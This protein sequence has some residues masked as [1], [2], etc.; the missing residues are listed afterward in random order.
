MK[1]RDSLSRPVVPPATTPRPAVTPGQVPA[2]SA[3]PIRDTVQLTPTTAAQV[4]LQGGAGPTEA[5]LALQQP[6]L[7]T[8]RG[9]TLQRL[10]AAGGGAE[11]ATL[12]GTSAATGEVPAFTEEEADEAFQAIALASDSNDATA[13]VEWLDAHPDPADQQAFMDLL[14]QY[15][16]VAGNILN[17]TQH[18]SPEQKQQLANAVERAFESGAVTEEEFQ[19]AITLHGGSGASDTAEGIGELIGLTHDEALINA[20]VEKELENYQAEGGE[21]AGYRAYGMAQALSGLSGPALQRYME[22]HPEEMATIV[23]GLGRDGGYGYTGYSPALG[24]LLDKASKIQPPTD[25]S[26][27]LFEQALP[28]VGDNEAA[29]QGL[30]TFMERNL[31]AILELYTDDSGSLTADGQGKLSE[32]LA[33]TLFSEPALEGSEGLRDAVLEKM[34][35]LSETLEAEANTNPPSVESQRAARLLGSLVGTVE[36]GF[37]VAVDQLDQEN[38]AVD[39]FVD[40]LFK[41]TDFIP[42][43]P[44]PGGGLIKDKGIDALKDWV[45]GELH[46]DAQD[47]NDAI[48]FHEAFAED[49][50]N[51]A[52]RS[53][54]D[55]ARADAF[56]NAARGLN[57]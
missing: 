51:P 7:A 33:R 42:D 5:D 26:L 30:A 21:A 44:F 37:Q 35:E 38:A 19:A 34:G 52:L 57:R 11:V 32:A 20:Y 16:G 55:S 31:D 3:N 41:A 40:F 12:A 43:L 45:K 49:I 23:D 10:V 56:I 39:G 22:A 50:D 2:T 9:G 14:F 48:P 18:L 17:E 8:V 29:R 46:K 6:S 13:V 28:L 27:A 24:N 15:E 47:P 1:T 25:E 53:F 54:Y 4:E 36:G